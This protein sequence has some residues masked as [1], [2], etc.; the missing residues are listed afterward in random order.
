M[1]GTINC[2]TSNGNNIK[3]EN[4]LY[5]PELKSNLLSVTEL[6]NKG[7]DILFTKNKFEIKKRMMY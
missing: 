7:L 1:I 6:Q 2:S 4:V 5:V 3:I